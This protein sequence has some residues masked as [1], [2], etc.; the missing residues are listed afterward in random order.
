MVVDTLVLAEDH[1]GVDAW[2]LLHAQFPPK[3]PKPTLTAYS[4]SKHELST[5]NSTMF[6]LSVEIYEYPRLLSSDNFSFFSKLL[7][8]LLWISSL[9]LVA[10]S[11][12]FWCSQNPFHCLKITSGRSCPS[13]KNDSFGG[14]TKTQVIW[15]SATLL[16]LWKWDA[17][18]K[19]ELNLLLM[20]VVLLCCLS[21]YCWLLSLVV[22]V[23]V[24]SSTMQTHWC[25]CSCSWIWNQAI[26]YLIP[27]QLHR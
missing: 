7:R 3:E 24:A 4:R 16:Q 18:Q 9:T 1:E 26:V 27:C 23:L 11:L 19:T 20:L 25:C 22:L 6:L 14:Y 5:Q 8:S 13:T 2:C 10:S 12:R 21:C 15:A 17:Q